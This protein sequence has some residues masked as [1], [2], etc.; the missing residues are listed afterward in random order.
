MRAGLEF[1]AEAI[2]SLEEKALALKRFGE[3]FAVLTERG[4][5]HTFDESG[6]QLAA[7]AGL[8]GE[9]LAHSWAEPGALGLLSQTP[10]GHR[11]AFLNLETGS[12]VSSDVAGQAAGVAC[13]SRGLAYWGPGAGLLKGYL[14]FLS[15]HGSWKVE[16]PL[17]QT[18]ALS[19][20]TLVGVALDGRILRAELEPGKAPAFTTLGKVPGRARKVIPL[21]DAVVLVQ[22]RKVALVSEKGVVSYDLAEEARLAKH[23]GG[24]VAVA[25]G[26]RLHL[27]DVESWKLSTLEVGRVYDID[28]VE[29][30]VYALTEEKISFIEE[31][32]E[33]EAVNLAGVPAALLAAGRGF[34][35][36]FLQMLAV[37]R[38]E[39]PAVGATVK[40]LGFEG[41]TPVYEVQIALRSSSSL[42]PLAGVEAQIET[43]EGIQRVVLDQEG[44][45]TI[46]TRVQR[47]TLLRVSSRG[48]KAAE[49]KLVP[50]SAEAVKELARGDKLVRGDSSVWYVQEKL[51]SG[52]FGTVYRVLDPLQERSLAVKLLPM[53]GAPESVIG[54]LLQEAWLLSQASQ[55]VN[56]DRKRAVEVYGFEKFKAVG[57]T[58][59]EKGDVYGLVM[60]YIEGGSLAG[61]ISA[62][63]APADLKLR[64]A[65]QLSESLAKLH[66]E[67]IVHG[68]IKPQNILLRQDTPL[69]ADF[70]AARI[71][72]IAGELLPIMAYT[73]EYAPPEALKGQ[74]SE[75]SD[76]YSLGT[77]LIELLA[78]TLP[79]PQSTNIPSAAIERIRRLKAGG[80]LLELLSRMRRQDSRQRPSAREVYETLKRLYG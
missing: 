64:I 8:E 78:G 54:E 50:P 42:A 63:T 69:L 57:Y 12:R 44:R 14:C 73:P 3:K 26:S 67:G 62:G 46:K 65:V 41:S 61:L 60:E 18:A 31:G 55:K 43:E 56:K 58:G 27:L 29:G 24:Y 80:K 33:V 40:F 11:V 72:R 53:S 45:A 20:D 16:T 79:A 25:E 6:F 28:S 35:L 68:D 10:R 19:G 52:G 5:V 2:Y 77:V 21:P 70:G 71:A 32:S 7:E 39:P 9:V 23:V 30:R 22:A 38:G 74:L 47:P 51:G 59:A 48:V 36:Y 17:L 15:E 76:V 13:S 75:K 49:V 4:R 37:G 66:E 1:H 34:A